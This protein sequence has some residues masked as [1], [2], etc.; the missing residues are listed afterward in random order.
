MKTQ[1]NLALILWVLQAKHPSLLLCEHRYSYCG[2]NVQSSLARA[3]H[4]ASPLFSRLSLLEKEG[5]SDRVWPNSVSLGMEECDFLSCPRP[6]SWPWAEPDL[7]VSC[8]SRLSGFL[9]SALGLWTLNCFE[10]VFDRRNLEVYPLL[11]DLFSCVCVHACRHKC[12]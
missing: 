9:P 11:N 6:H 10:A 12:M 7:E 1:I 2:F 4:S 5:T 3:L 8:P